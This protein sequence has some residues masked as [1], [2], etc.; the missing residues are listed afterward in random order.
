MTAMSTAPQTA[1]FNG[2]FRDLF[3][4]GCCGCCG[5]ARYSCGGCCGCCGGCCGGFL[6]FGLFRRYDCCGC[7][8]GSGVSYACYGS[9]YP[10]YGGPVMAYTPVMN[11]GLTCHGGPIPSA[12]PPVFNPAPGV[13]FAPPEVAPPAT[14]PE[15][16]GLRPV[17]YDAPATPVAAGG[18][19]ARATVVV[20]LPVDARLYADNTALRLTGAE[21]R[22]V[23]PELPA[24]QE[25]T[26][27]FKVEYERDGE[28]VSVTKR[29]PVRAGGSATIEFA[30]LT[31]ARPAGNGPAA[32]PVSNPNAN[33]TL[34][35]P[36]ASPEPPVAPATAAPAPASPA[37]DRATITVKLP[38][39]AT[40]YVDD[41]KSPSNEPVRQFSTPPLPAGR[42]FAYLLKAEVVRD[43][44]PES[45]T[46]KVPFRAGERVT[47]DFTGITK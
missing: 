4:C 13:P 47:I 20:R 21:R 46:Q 16:F 35:A 28:L 17:G 36:T 33:A 25:Y 30:D 26:Y 45:F 14:A 15:R 2:F 18:Q 12:P 8:G 19:G 44:R 7:C 37:S 11:G 34:A 1:E 5:G 38:P 9:P 6:G 43:G 32:T 39:G 40:L 22:F 10:S 27:R 41:R 42:E 24:G 23:T 3:G 29:V 31:A